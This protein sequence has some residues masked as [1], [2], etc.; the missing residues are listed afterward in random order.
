MKEFAPG[1]PRIDHADFKDLVNFSTNSSELAAIRQAA[2]FC[3]ESMRHPAKINIHLLQAIIDYVSEPGERVMDIMS[4][5]GTILIAAQQGRSVTCIE[6]SPK[7]AEWINK[8]VDNMVQK[9]STI[10]DRVMVINMSAQKALP[11]PCNHIVFSPPYAN[12]MQKKKM[13]DGDM[14]ASLYGLSKEEEEDFTEYMNQPDNVGNR[15]RFFYNMEMERIYNLCFQS[16]LP[17]GTMTVIIKDY[18]EKGKRVFLSDWLIRTCI[19]IGFE[20]YAWFKWPALGSPFTRIYR[21]QGKNTVD[22][23]DIIILRRLL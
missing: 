8:T 23:E 1:V 18:I 19:R 16:L 12:I 7:Y 17:G 20:Q 11:L 15:N 9:D 21:A 2:G 6:I 3:E 13:T 22:D 5:T 10:R 4:G 14:T